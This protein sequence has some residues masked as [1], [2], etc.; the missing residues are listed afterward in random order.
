MNARFVSLLSGVLLL[1]SAAVADAADKPGTAAPAKKGPAATQ[2]A[3]E[4]AKDEPALAA[5]SA[6]SVARN[7]QCTWL[8]KRVMLLLAREDVVAAGEFSRFYVGFGCPETHLGNA[9]GCLIAAEIPAADFRKA[10][11]AQASPEA[12]K[13]A[14]TAAVEAKKGTALRADQCWADPETPL[15]ERKEAPAAVQPPP[16]PAPAPAPAPQTPAPQP[17]K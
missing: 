17:A 9:F 1:G 8:G 7:N 5:K 13:A 10:L 11:D 4:S 6:E 15:P 2:P 12:R 14:E 3:K 16:A